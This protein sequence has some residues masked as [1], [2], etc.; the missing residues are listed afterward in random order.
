MKQYIQ[1]SRSYIAKYKQEFAIGAIVFLIAIAILVA[2]TI[3]AYNST[4]KIVYQ[5][6]KACDML[7]M[8]E[9]RTLLGDKTILSNSKNPSISGNTAVS[10]CGYTDGNPDTQNMMVAAI[11]VRSGVNDK[12]VEQNKSEFAAGKPTKNVETI[13]GIGDTAYFNRSLGQLNVLDGRKWIILSYGLGSEPKANS[14]DDV[15]KLATQVIEQQPITEK[16]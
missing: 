4:P 8:D 13:D 12:G 16:F 9:A 5:P 14:L 15:M 1:D 3:V 11:I 10:A 6:A 2:L 7:T